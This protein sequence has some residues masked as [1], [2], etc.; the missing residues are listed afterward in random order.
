MP[1]G[2]R[3][4]F[5]ICCEFCWVPA[6]PRLNSYSLTSF[7]S[8]GFIFMFMLTFIFTLT[9][10]LLSPGGPAWSRRLP[11]DF[12]FSLL[13]RLWKACWWLWLGWLFPPW[14]DVDSIGIFGLRR[15]SKF[16]GASYVFR[17]ALFYAWADG[18]TASRSRLWP[19]VC[20]FPW[21]PGWS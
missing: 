13:F 10:T 12:F 5:S 14:N 11:W 2:P 17:F 1:P 15:F 9:F 7:I 16:A 19:P 20:C 8:R 21:L 6:P 3:P 4:W 18:M